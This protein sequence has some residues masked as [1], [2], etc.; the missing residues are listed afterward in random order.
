MSNSEL[1]SSGIAKEIQ[2]IVF[3]LKNGITSVIVKIPKIRPITT[4][5]RY[6]DFIF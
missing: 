5:I 6:P 3:R 1:L 2:S 4:R